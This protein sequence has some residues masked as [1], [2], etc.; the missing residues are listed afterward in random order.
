MQTTTDFIEL[1][2]RVGAELAYQIAQMD[3]ASTCKGRRFWADPYAYNPKAEIVHPI[4]TSP[5]P[6]IVPRTGDAPREA[7]VN[8]VVSGRLDV[9]RQELQAS[10]KGLN[11]AIEGSKGKTLLHVAARMYSL[12]ARDQR[13]CGRAR[14]ER[15][16]Q[17][18]AELLKAGAN[19]V[20]RD[21]EQGGGHFPMGT[22]TEGYAPACLRERMIRE[23]AEE[24]VGWKHGY[25]LAHCS[26]AAPHPYAKRGIKARRV[27][28]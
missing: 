9:F 5:L 10:T 11:D 3:M 16:E 2:E 6:G 26:V 28:A 17:I 27:A 1:P 20:Q 7:L 14:A 24:R 12:F 8:A 18:T 4:D 19:P 23:A 13:Q 25:Q 15:F 22:Y 21:G